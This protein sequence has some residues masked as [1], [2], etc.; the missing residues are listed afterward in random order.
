MSI[1]A[2][3]IALAGPVDALHE[4]YPN[5][6]KYKYQ[7]HLDQ[8]HMPEAWKLAQGED[9]IV[10]VLD[11]GVAYEA[12]GKYHQVEDLAGVT[13]VAPFDFVDNDKHANDDHGH[14]THVTGTVAQATH[15]GKGVAGV[16]VGAKI[17]PL[18]V[19]GADGSGSVAGIADAIRYAAD[20]KAKV[21]N[22]SL[23]GPLPSRVLKKACEYAVKKGVTI[24]AAAGNEGRSK[25]GYPAGYPGVIAVAATQF[26][27]STTFYSNSGKDVDIAAPGGNTRVDQ[28]KDG[29]ND[30]VL[31]NTIEIG[32]PTKS[33]Y[34][35][36]MGTSMAS[37]HVAGVAALIVGT[38]VTEPAAVEK[39]LLE[40]ARRP[41]A[42]TYVRD[43]YGAGIVDAAAAVKLALQGVK[44]AKADDGAHKNSA[45]TTHHVLAGFL[46]LLMAGAVA[47]MRRR[48]A[49]GGSY[50]VG[51]VIGAAGVTLLPANALFTSALLPLGVLSIGWGAAKLRAPLA[52]V[53][54]GFAAGLLLL[55]VA[56]IDI[57]WVPGLFGFDPIWLG[58][59]ALASVGL[60]RA[61]LRP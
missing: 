25:V 49:V 37:P 24:I 28:N 6:P 58:V 12:Y 4:G 11:T 35:I 3:E 21:I 27:E 10:A 1:P 33:D 55:A 42:Q 44:V 40:T 15:N 41:N 20:N 19:L 7:W 31:Q 34:L 54:A 9:V 29:M 50:L 45:T 61:A 22:M 23:G 36:F 52:G 48:I 43:R 46:G 32:N 18:K 53:A 47:S 59:N 8:I 5:D 39:V 13:F 38:G 30:G 14:G 26:D 60:A 2:G 56:R 57:A 17:M 51:A 16:A